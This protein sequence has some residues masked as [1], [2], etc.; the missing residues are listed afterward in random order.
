[1]SRIVPVLIAA[2]LVLAACGSD[3]ASEVT[4]NAGTDFEV[5]VGE[6]P[7]FDGCGSSGEI[8]NYEWVIVDA[9]D[10]QPDSDGKELRTVMGDCSF[11]LENAM[12]IDDVGEWTIELVV[13]D[14]EAEASDQVVVTV[15]E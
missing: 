3:S 1:M 5:T 9:P 7:V 6:I 12:I 14:G 15:T 4:S 10:S 11:E 8:T 13:T 2:G